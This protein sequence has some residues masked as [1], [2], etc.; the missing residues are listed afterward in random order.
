MP[1]GESPLIFKQYLDEIYDLNN[2]KL[3]EFS[4]REIDIYHVPIVIPV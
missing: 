1:K 2:A 4:G 3:S